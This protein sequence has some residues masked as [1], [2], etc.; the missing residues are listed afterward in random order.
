ML[1]GL[2]L[3]HN[4]VMS[5]H[6]DHHLAIG[7]IQSLCSTQFSELDPKIYITVTVLPSMSKDQ[8]YYLSAGKIG[9]FYNIQLLWLK[10]KSRVN[11]LFMIK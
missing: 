6:K 10:M 7:D 2:E 1:E 3:L 9:C 11:L 4:F 8:M 5:I